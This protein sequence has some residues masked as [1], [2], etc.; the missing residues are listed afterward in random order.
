[1]PEEGESDR[2]VP[3]LG[4]P[5]PAPAYAA[6]EGSSSGS[7]VELFMASDSSSP[8]NGGMVTA[9][10]LSNGGVA[11]LPLDGSV[12]K[13][14]GLPFKATADDVCRFYASFSLSADAV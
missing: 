5:E 12:V 7:S 6:G 9:G 4:L 2:V 13:M 8:P 11:S 10:A 3:T 14:K 1:M